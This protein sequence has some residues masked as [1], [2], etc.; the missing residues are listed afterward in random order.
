MCQICFNKKYYRR[1]GEK[2][3]GASTCLRSGPTQRQQRVHYK[4]DQ[5]ND[6]HREG[7]PVLKRGCQA[8]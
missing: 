3:M 8:H 7:I 2:Q 1:T 6:A 5:G 4:E